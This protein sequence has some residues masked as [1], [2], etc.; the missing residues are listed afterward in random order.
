MENCKTKLHWKDTKRWKS[1]TRWKW[2]NFSEENEVAEIFRSYF[3]GIVVGLNIEWC[4]IYKEYSDP[5][6]ISIK[7]FEKHPSILKTKE[8]NSGC[9]FSFE[10]VSLEDVKKV[11]RQLDIL[12]ASQLLDILNKIIKQN[13]DIFCE[14]FFVNINHSINNSTFPE[15]LKLADV[16]P[17]FKK[18][19]RT[20]KEN[21]RPVSILPNISKIYVR[22]LYKQ[23]S[24]YFNVIFSRN[25]SG[26]L[27]GL[28]IILIFQILLKMVN[29]SMSAG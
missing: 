16:K 23:L 2:Y 4:E 8:L 17:V 22:Y 11:T 29:G 27:K 25:Q 21:Y 18:N 26:F 20:D 12:K 7:T 9:R 13:G 28:M 5:I 3:D 19:S 1:S 10:N 14:F 24:D 6:L 15:Q